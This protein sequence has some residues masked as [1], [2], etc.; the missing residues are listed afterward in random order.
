M[1]MMQLVEKLPDVAEIVLDK[2]V[3]LSPLP[4][5]HEDFSITFNFRHLDPDIDCV[6][7]VPATMAKFRREKLLNHVVTQAL[8]RFKWMV[9]GKFL[10][11]FNSIVFLT[12]VIMYSCFVVKE[13]N[14]SALFFGSSNTTASNEINQKSSFDEVAPRVIFVFLIVQ[15]IKEAM[16][17]SWMRFAYFKDGTNL[18]ELLMYAMVWIFTL[19]SLFGKEIYSIETRWNAGLIGLFLSYIVLTL[20]CRRYGELGLYVTMYSEVLWTFLKVISTFLIALIGYSL[21]FYL[22]LGH[23]V[24]VILNNC[25]PKWRWIV[26][27]IRGD[28]NL[29]FADT[30]ESNFFL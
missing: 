29:L 25:S 19:P 24:R 2:C 26:A 11:F 15:L 12:F 1:P 28:V 18:L 21:V 22:L 17:L 4:P 8:L 9:L 5:S 7:F 14:R 30:K 20:H 10:T 27:Y 3:T 16:Q 23:Q 13:R 6:C